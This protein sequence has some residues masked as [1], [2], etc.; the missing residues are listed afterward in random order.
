MGLVLTQRM[1]GTL[2]DGIRLCRGV[3]IPLGAIQRHC[4]A[5]VT[6]W[7]FTVRHARGCPLKSPGS[8][9]CMHLPPMH[10]RN[11]GGTKARPT[12]STTPPFNWDERDKRDERDEP[13]GMNRVQRSG[14]EGRKPIA[15]VAR[16]W[17]QA[18]RNRKPWKG[19]SGCVRD[20]ATFA[21]CGAPA[22][23]AIPAPGSGD[24]GY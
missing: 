4:R 23:R 5:C 1:E 21:P 11:Q 17:N 14:P 15:R 7:N 22:R 12:R 20:A 18:P 19:G 13:T 3:Q 24:P 6:D 10:T 8:M 16:P 2:R 9:S